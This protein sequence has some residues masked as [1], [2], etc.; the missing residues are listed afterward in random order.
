MQNNQIF[1]PVTVRSVAHHVTQMDAGG[2]G[3]VQCDVWLGCPD[4]IVHLPGEAFLR[5]A[6]DGARG[7]VPFSLP[8]GQGT[9][10]A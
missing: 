9:G 8:H 4:Q 6:R 10:E 2:V 1:E 7:G 3:A 5:S